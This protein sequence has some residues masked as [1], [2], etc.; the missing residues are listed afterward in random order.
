MWSLPIL[1][2]INFP[3]F[4]GENPPMQVPKKSS[5]S[6]VV[7]CCVLLCDV[8]CCFVVVAIVVAIVVGV[9]NLS[10]SLFPIGNEPN[11]FCLCISFRLFLTF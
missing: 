2:H 7:C 5:S 10:H 8:V 11:R 1:L 6:V 9:T 4:Q 3:F